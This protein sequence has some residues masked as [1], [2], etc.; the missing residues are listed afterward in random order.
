MED[1]V[2]SFIWKDLEYELNKWLEDIRNILENV[3]AVPDILALRKLQG[4]AEAIRNMLKLP[5]AVM[6]NIKIDFE[7]ERSKEDA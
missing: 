3:E 4:N 6:E 1:F 2:E 5:F 7:K